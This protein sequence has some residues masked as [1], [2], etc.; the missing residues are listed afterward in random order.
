MTKQHRPNIRTTSRHPVIPITS[1]V[2]DGML[3]NSHPRLRLHANVTFYPKEEN[4]QR[5]ITLQSFLWVYITGSKICNPF[6]TRYDRDSQTLT[7][8]SIHLDDTS[9][10]PVDDHEVPSTEQAT[11]PENQR[12]GHF[13]I[14]RFSLVDYLESH[15]KA[16]LDKSTMNR[17]ARMTLKGCFSIHELEDGFG[18]G[19]DIKT[20]EQGLP[21]DAERIPIS[22]DFQVLRDAYE[23]GEETIC[24]DTFAFFPKKQDGSDSEP[25]AIIGSVCNG[26]YRLVIL[27]P[28]VIN[29]IFDYEEKWVENFTSSMS[30]TYLPFAPATGAKPQ[31]QQEPV[32][33][34]DEEDSTGQ[35]QQPDEQPP[36][37]TQTTEQSENRELPRFPLDSEINPDELNH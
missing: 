14:A 29:V 10:K 31:E 18:E 2:F 27:P 6:K 37:T 23:S 34:G 1:P 28:S 11:Q 8:P 33:V 36:Q 19:L 16:P 25:N 22:A 5:R 30:A 9:T 4:D 24:G 13:S 3:I 7:V 15:F 32:D 17:F 12:R 21:V 35:P 20:D 26:Y